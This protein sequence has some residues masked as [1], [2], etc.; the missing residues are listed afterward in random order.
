MDVASP[1]CSERSQKLTWPPFHGEKKQGLSTPPSV[2]G[3]R[4]HRRALSRPKQHALPMKSLLE[5]QDLSFNFLRGWT[6]LAHPSF[7]KKS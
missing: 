2:P 6:S 7:G 1:L 4:A 3:G 5:P